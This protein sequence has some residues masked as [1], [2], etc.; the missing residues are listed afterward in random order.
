MVDQTTS[1]ASLRSS[2]NEHVYAA[3]WCQFRASI[4]ITGC[5]DGIVEVWDLNE[6]MTK[7]QVVISGLK[8]KEQE[9]TG[10]GDQKEKKETQNSQKEMISVRTLSFNKKLPVFA[11]G[12]DNGWI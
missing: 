5:R 8:T 9:E 3:E 12:Y 1:L 7:P 4:F 2:S 6:S 11:A 10:D